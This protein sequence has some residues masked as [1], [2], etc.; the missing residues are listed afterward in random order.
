[1][2][3]TGVS[4]LEYY[5]QFFGDKKHAYVDLLPEATSVGARLHVP[6]EEKTTGL[7][8]EKA[9]EQLDKYVHPCWCHPELIYADDT[10]GNE[11][12][13]HKREQ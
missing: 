12:W 13:L 2:I 5:L 6:L 8:P 4:F 10:K 1:M 9:M 7:S 3:K 11:V